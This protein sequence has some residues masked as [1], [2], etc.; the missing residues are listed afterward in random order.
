M[1]IVVGETSRYKTLEG[2]CFM[3]HKTDLCHDQQFPFQK[4]KRTMIRCLT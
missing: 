4:K 3:R 1:N 2:Y